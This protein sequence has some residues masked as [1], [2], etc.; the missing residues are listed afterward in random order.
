MSRWR[1]KLD[2]E[3][4]HIEAVKSLIMNEV[5]EETAPRRCGRTV[6]KEMTVKPDEI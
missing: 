5:N 4:R 2:E 1:Y 6:K 3:Q